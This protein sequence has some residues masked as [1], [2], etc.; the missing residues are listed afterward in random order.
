MSASSGG[1]AISTASLDCIRMACLGRSSR[2]LPVTRSASDL[3]PW[4]RKAYGRSP[5]ASSVPAYWDGSA[6]RG[7]STTRSERSTSLPRGARRWYCGVRAIWYQSPTRYTAVR[8]APTRP[9][10]C[11]IHVDGTPW[12]RFDL[13]R[14]TSAACAHSW[15][16]REAHY[17]CA[18]HGRHA[19]S[20]Y[21]RHCCIGPTTP[22]N[23]SFAWTGAIT[24]TAALFL[25]VRDPSR[26]RR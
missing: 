14:T 5:C 23:S 18:V 16:R 21:C 13:R 11:A 17:A 3:S 8:S 12:P 9:L 19:I 20:L 1:C 6:I 7:M 2:L 26:Y 15:Q 4:L 22:C 24:A 10:S 25:P